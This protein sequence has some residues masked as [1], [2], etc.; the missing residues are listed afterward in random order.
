MCHGDATPITF[1]W[2]AEINNYLAHHS[3]EHQCRDFDAIFN[4]AQGR[5]R[6]GL[7]ADG[8]HQNVELNEPEMFD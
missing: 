1:E 8:A 5:A 7:V 4:W 6:T 2:N 3:T